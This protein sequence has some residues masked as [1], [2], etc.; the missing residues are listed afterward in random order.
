MSYRYFKLEEFDCKETGEN[1]MQ[2][3]FIAKLD[4]LRHECGFPFIVNSGY[5]SVVHSEERGKLMPGMHT[6]GEAADIR[7]NGSDQRYL[8]VMLAIEQGFRGIVVAKT[9]VHLDTRQAPRMWTY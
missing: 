1:E 9:Y 3:E 7:I 6:K 4:D 2:P 5:R 8:I